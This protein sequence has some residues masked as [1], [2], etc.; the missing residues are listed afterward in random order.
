MSNVIVINKVK[1]V[2][3]IIVMRILILVLDIGL[4]FVI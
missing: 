4:L 3:M 2:V 1:S